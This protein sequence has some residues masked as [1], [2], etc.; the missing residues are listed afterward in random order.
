[1]ASEGLIS[2][3]LTEVVDSNLGPKGQRSTASASRE[4][5][6]SWEPP[7]S[8]QHSLW[9]PLDSHP[10]DW[11]WAIF[12]IFHFPPPP[13][14]KKIRCSW[15]VTDPTGAR[16]HLPANTESR[17][18]TLPSDTPLLRVRPRHGRSHSQSLG[19]TMSSYDTHSSSHQTTRNMT[20]VPGM[21]VDT[22]PCPY[23]HVVR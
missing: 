3:Q 9:L 22:W 14:L 5:R 6:Q 17:S 4:D 7:A 10:P 15:S 19:F 8:H 20:A 2:D 21:T 23:N 12:Y 13:F 11:E 16:F 1:M 18:Q